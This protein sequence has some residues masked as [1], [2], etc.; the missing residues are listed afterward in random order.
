MPSRAF[1]DEG[2]HGVNFMPSR[3][4]RSVVAA[5]RSLRKSHSAA[6]QREQ[7]LLHAR[8]LAFGRRREVGVVGART[9][10]SFGSDR[11]VTRATATEVVGLEI[12]CRFGKAEPVSEIVRQ[13]DEV[14]QVGHDCRP[15]R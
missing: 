4:S 2:L 14:E 11:I 9:I 3:T 13:I 10:L 15:L 12:P 6:A 5:P 1:K 7:E 8:T